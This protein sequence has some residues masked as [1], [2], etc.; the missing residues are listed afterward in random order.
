MTL[1]TSCVAT[2]GLR[3]MVP[4]KYHRQDS[5]PPPYKSTADWQT[6]LDSHSLDMAAFNSHS[7]EKVR[8]RISGNPAC[9]IND[10]TVNIAPE[11]R[12]LWRTKLMDKGHLHD[13]NV[14][15]M[16]HYHPPG[17]FGNVQVLPVPDAEDNFWDEDVRHAT[18][19]APRP[20]SAPFNQPHVEPANKFGDRGVWPYANNE[21]WRGLSWKYLAENEG[22]CTAT[23]LSATAPP[24]LGAPPPA[25]TASGSACSCAYDGP[26]PEAAGSR[27]DR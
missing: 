21:S 26:H 20:A 5:P 25:Q 23:W 22:P 18:A 9:H 4:D 8:L 7:S 14:E 1:V 3:T 24:T 11:C 12:K 27:T 10:P 6:H 15:V 2:P 17:T 19:A 16:L 13:S